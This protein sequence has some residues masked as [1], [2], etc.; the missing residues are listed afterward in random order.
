MPQN[1]I[2]FRKL[3][4]MLTQGLETDIS[5]YAATCI[6]YFKKLSSNKTHRSL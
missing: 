2:D 4:H 5:Q 1:Q 3:D 6:H